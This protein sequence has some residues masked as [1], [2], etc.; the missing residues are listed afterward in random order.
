MKRG[1]R[2]RRDVPTHTDPKGKFFTAVVHKRAVAAKIQT[3]THLI[4]GNLHVHP[5]DRV[6]DELNR[7]EPFLAVTDARLLGSDGREVDRTL[8]I[9]IN[10]KHIIWLAPAD[11]SADEEPKS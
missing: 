10:K 9:S 5:D 6:S 8:F 2:E 11:S 4:E 3:P 7:E 1:A